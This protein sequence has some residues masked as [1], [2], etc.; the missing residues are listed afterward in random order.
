[1]YD[2]QAIVS[3]VGTCA[4]SSH[5]VS[6][7]LNSNKWYLFDDATVKEVSTAEVLKQ[8]AYI[9]FMKGKVHLQEKL[10]LYVHVHLAPP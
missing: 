10:V 9:L 1:M 7:I 4:T 5:Y 2:L 8:Q 3:H 6:Y